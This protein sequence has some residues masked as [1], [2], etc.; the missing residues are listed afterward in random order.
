[1]P[2]I[3]S[4][5]INSASGT[6]GTT[7]GL[8][9]LNVATFQNCINGKL[10]DTKAH[11]R[12]VNPANLEPGP[13]VPCA[14]KEDLDKAVDAAKTAFKHWSKVTFKDRR[15]AVMAYA[16]A[17]EEIKEEFIRLLTTEQGKPVS[18]RT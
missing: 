15:A 1:M 12:A 18:L 10:V 6:N 9:A 11:R 14:T 8:P 16:D 13:D 2:H 7:H 5:A 3:A 17:M 4:E